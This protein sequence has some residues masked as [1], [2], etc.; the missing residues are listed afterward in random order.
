MVLD[1]LKRLA[2]GLKGETPEVAPS[3]RPPRLLDQGALGTPRLHLDA[4]GRALALWRNGQSLYAT[5]FWTGGSDASPTLFQA[6]PG[7]GERLGELTSARFEDTVLAAWTIQAEGLTH[8]VSRFFRGGTEGDTRTALTVPGV[9]QSLQVLVDRRGDGLMVWCASDTEGYHVRALGFDARSQAWDPEPTRLD[10]PLDHPTPV[11]LALGPKG[12]AL[13]VWNHEGGGYEG[14][15]TSHY[16]AKERLWSDRPMGVV[17]ALA[18]SFELAQDAQ[19]N[20]SLLYLRTEAGK[21]ALD[22]CVMSAATA[23][24]HGPTRLAQAQDLQQPRLG[25]A[26]GGAAVALWRQSEVGGTMRLF[27]RTFQNGKWSP[28]PEALEADMGSGREHAFALGAA[29]RGTLLWAQASAQATG[30]AEAIHLR[31]FTKGQWGKVPLQ[32]GQPVK[33]AHHSLCVDVNG[34]HVAALW[35]AGVGRNGLMGA[36]G[37]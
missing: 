16:F 5:R 34:P 30:G 28:R 36:V 6:D 2:Q 15:V 17:N 9:V 32:L 12:E 23:T 8:L 7:K 11:A 33:F 31:S 1:A 14:L 27:S 21:L 24:W 22:A 13:A 29:G 25:M 20:V 4:R 19:G 37:Q 18:R 3:W 10:G 35:L 26:D